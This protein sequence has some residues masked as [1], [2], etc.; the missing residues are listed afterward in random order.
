M[1]RPP[2]APPQPQLRLRWDQ[3]RCWDG[4]PAAQ[5]LHCQE[6]LTLLLRQVVTT[7]FGM[8]SPEDEREDPADAS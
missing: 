6:L 5:R 7:E 3:N 8:R 1:R 2:L 4:L